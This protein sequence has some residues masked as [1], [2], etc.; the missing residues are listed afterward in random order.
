[1]TTLTTRLFTLQD[2]ERRRIARELHD[3]AAQNVFA[4][5]MNLN[6][7][8]KAFNHRSSK[9]KSVLSDSQQLAEQSL[10]ELRTL[11]YL[12]HPPVLDQ[13]G[14]AD[15]LHWFA[16]GFSDRSGIYVDTRAVQEIGRLAPDCERALF[17]IVQEGLTNVRRHSGSDTASILL[18]K[19]GGEVRLHIQDQGHG[20]SAVS[21]NGYADK[22]TGFG[23]GIA[24]MRQR[25][26]QLGG[27]I[28]IN[29]GEGGTTITVVVPATEEMA[30]SQLS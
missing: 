14:L 28:E 25:L 18:E 4:I 8:Q 6:R 2:E 26:T 5:T 9:M 13:T 27:R 23:V 3:G 30:V 29:S 11:S 24:G 21:G 22:S 15:A 17:R 7:L 20:I 19:S 12:L 10:S 1:L 16:R